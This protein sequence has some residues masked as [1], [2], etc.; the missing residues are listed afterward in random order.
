MKR[1]ISSL[2]VFVI[3]CACSDLGGLIEADGGSS[4]DL[5]ERD[6][7]SLDRGG[8]SDLGGDASP[9]CGRSAPPADR[10]RFVVIS[11]PFGASGKAKKYEVLALSQ[12]GVLSQTGTKF[13]MRRNFSTPMRFS[14]DGAIGLSVQDDGSLGIFAIA[15]DGKVQVVDPAFEPTY[16]TDVFGSSDPDTFYVVY[17]A[18]RN[19]GGGVYRM[20]L[21][22]DGTPADQG[23]VTPAKLLRGMAWLDDQRAL[24][25]A[26]DIGSSAASHD[27]HVWNAS[28]G[29]VS[30]G[31]DVFSDEPGVS[32]L[33]ISPDGQLAIITDNGFAS[34]QR[35][36]A[37]KIDA[38]GNPVDKLVVSGFSDPTTVL[39]SPFGD[40]AIVLDTMGSGIKLLRYD[41]TSSPMLTLEGDVTTSTK[42]R[43]ARLGGADHARKPQRTLLRR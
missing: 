40:I 11:R 6:G 24:V 42:P 8:G 10:D 26:F 34:G 22:C 37:V 35:V 19:H 4:T 1:L 29:T 7:P 43:P 31:L 28:A 13:E 9:S 27:V 14:K 32:S 18:W 21:G 25:A 17:G 39:F 2:F 33:S 12:A 30:G 20:R 3:G 5:Q 38:N 23:M 36:A 16:V 41:A 15:P